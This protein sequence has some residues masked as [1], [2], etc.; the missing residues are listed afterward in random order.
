MNQF[1]SNYLFF[2]SYK[3]QI[4]SCVCFCQF[5]FIYSSNFCLKSKKKK[6]CW[7]TEGYSFF[8]TPK[9]SNFASF[10]SFSFVKSIHC[11]NPSQ[12]KYPYTIAQGK[13][14]LLLFFPSA[15]EEKTSSADSVS[16]P[17]NFLKTHFPPK[18]VAVSPNGKI[19]AATGK[20]GVCV[21]HKQ[22]NK[23]NEMPG[24]ECIEIFKKKVAAGIA[25][26]QKTGNSNKN[27]TE[28][29]E[30][31]QNQG[32]FENLNVESCGLCWISNQHLVLMNSLSN[33][34][35]RVYQVCFVFFL[36]KYSK[37]IHK[38]IQVNVTE[39]SS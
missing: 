12:N 20:S 36:L 4:C 7:G 10:Y 2:S 6:Q 15:N 13:D 22:I 38:I 14:K 35:G 8:V 29:F 39:I 3:H 31:I 11:S 37:L 1:S 19:V 33:E 32:F 34:R 27:L 16:L 23:W 30:N 24:N 28:F 25:K 18:L 9:Q 5:S 17:S 26:Q 21:F